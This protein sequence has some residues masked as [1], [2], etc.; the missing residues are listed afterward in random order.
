[1]Q[2]YSSVLDKFLSDCLTS[3]LQSVFF[4][5]ETLAKVLFSFMMPKVSTWT[6]ALICKYRR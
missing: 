4:K 2:R 1:M 6:T 5:I 3:V